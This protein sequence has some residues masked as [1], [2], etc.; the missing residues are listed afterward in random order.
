MTYYIIGLT[1]RNASGKGTVASLLM[2]RS[3]SY[4]SLSDTLRT[5][6]AEKG[7]EES[8]DNLIAIGN[9]LREEGG[10]SVLADMMREKIV[11]PSDHVVDSI[12]NPYEVSSL[13]RKYD[14]HS[15]CLI[16]VDAKP[17]VRFERLSERNRKGDS[18]SWEQFLEQ[19][20]LEES[21]DNPNK[22]QLFATIKEADYNIDN[23]SSL[24]DLE[25]KLS[26]II[27]KL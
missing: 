1:G 18:S 21:S 16:A 25:N 7:I 19:E 13:R 22:Q 9:K 2:K 15:F 17:E 6:L 4:H 26:L 14:N 11:T 27:D 12:R 8:R 23:S 24:T 10:P 5:K 3:F 20:K